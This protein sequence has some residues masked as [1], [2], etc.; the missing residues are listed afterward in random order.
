MA[1]EEE[2]R[3]KAEV[4]VGKLKDQASKQILEVKIQ[5]VEEFKVSSKMRDMNVAFGQ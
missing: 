5:G 4:K 3:K 2:R 1:L